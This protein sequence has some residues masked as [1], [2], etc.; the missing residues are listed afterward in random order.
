MADLQIPPV[1]S[2]FRGWRNMPSYTRV[3]AP[4]CYGYQIDGTSFSRVIV[5]SFES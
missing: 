3:R 4:G 5:F 2:S 1:P